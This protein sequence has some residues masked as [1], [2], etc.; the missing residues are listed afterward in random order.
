MPEEEPLDLAGLLGM[1]ND[2]TSHVTLSG[3]VK[4]ITAL[5]RNI[6]G[7]PIDC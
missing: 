4:K 6:Q 2:T 5:G 3:T 1:T 7:S